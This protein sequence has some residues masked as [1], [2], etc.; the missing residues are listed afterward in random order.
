MGQWTKRT[1]VLSA[2]LCASLAFPGA[3]LAQ[4]V[5]VAATA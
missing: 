4:K 5:T 2:G 1:A 3:L